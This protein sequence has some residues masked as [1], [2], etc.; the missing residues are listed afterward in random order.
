[1]Y[2]RK[3]SGH[4]VMPWGALYSPAT[5]S[6]RISLLV[7]W[8][9]D[10]VRSE[11][12]AMALFERIRKESDKPDLEVGDTR[13]FL[14]SLQVPEPQDVGTDESGIYEYVIW[15]DLYYERKRGMGYE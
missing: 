7:H 1:M 5:M 15:L 2:R 13:I 8:E 6:G 4:P 14:V 9:R 11:A 10:P 12:A 3:G